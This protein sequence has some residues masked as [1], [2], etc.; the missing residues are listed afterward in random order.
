MVVVPS[1]L[2][3]PKLPSNRFDRLTLTGSCLF[4]TNSYYLF[5]INRLFEAVDRSLYFLDF[6]IVHKV[7]LQ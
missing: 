2:E 6:C 5:K 4:E 3:A 7:M 1:T